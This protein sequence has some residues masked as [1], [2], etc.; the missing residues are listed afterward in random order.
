MKY[1]TA[2]LLTL[3]LTGCEITKEELHWAAEACKDFKGVHSILPVNFGSA[4]VT[5]VDG[6]V[7]TV[8]NFKIFK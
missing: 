5:C 4:E 7:Y 8:N 1:L 2:L 6:S 3:F